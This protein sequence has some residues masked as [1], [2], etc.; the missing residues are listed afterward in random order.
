MQPSC[1]VC[2]SAAKRRN[3]LFAGIIILLADTMHAKAQS[4]CGGL[5]SIR[6]TTQLVYPPIARAAHFD[7]TVITLATF[8]LDGTVAKTTPVVGVPVMQ[9]AADTY[10]KGFQANPYSGPRECAIVITFRLIGL[11]VECGSPEDDL[12]VD[13]PS[14]QQV[15]AQHFTFT[16]RNSCVTITR[17]P[18]G[19]KIHRFHLW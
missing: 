4:S 12:R 16:L 6:E 14:V 3:L 15:D 1:L 9:N 17:D 11:S 10:V 13:V 7:G 18:A 5:T 2:H 8:N 19:K